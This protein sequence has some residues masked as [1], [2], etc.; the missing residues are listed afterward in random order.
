M[1][2][3]L[4][5]FGGVILKNACFQKTEKIRLDIRIISRERDCFEIQWRGQILPNFMILCI[6][7]IA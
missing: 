6:F 3:F 2:K 5:N 4:K 1:T 7:K